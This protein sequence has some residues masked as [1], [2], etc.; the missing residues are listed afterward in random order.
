MARKA[1][2]R[3]PRKLAR[4]LGGHAMAIAMAV[5]ATA[6]PTPDA[7]AEGVGPCQAD[8]QQGYR[9]CKR[10][11]KESYQLAKDTCYNLDHP[12]VEVCRDERNVCNQPI[13]TECDAA[14]D[15]CNET[16]AGAK[17]VC[18]DSYP[19]GT[20]E[21]DACID[22]AQVVAFICRD[23]AREIARPGLKTCRRAF[24]ICVSTECPPDAPV[25][26]ATAR[27]CKNDAKHIYEGCVMDCREEYQ[28]AKDTCLDRDHACVEAC[29]EIREACR[30]PI[31]EVRDLAIDACND[32]RANAIETC[33]SLYEPGTPERDVCVDQAQVEAFRCRDRARE[34]ARPG[35]KSCRDAF[36]TCAEACPP[37]GG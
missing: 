16:L 6:I 36:R 35:L 13:L 1:V 21:R 5:L 30:Q 28:L 34:D 3:M 33:Q 19:D 10:A 31:L 14:I 22:Q 9:E 12:C 27:A 8:A 17:A 24:R 18:R 29:R 4:F 20:P 7:R 15:T 11:C 26:R 25:D 23:G 37:A 2:L 32:D